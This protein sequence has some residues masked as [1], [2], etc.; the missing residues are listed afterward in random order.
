[1]TSLNCLVGLA[2]WVGLNIPIPHRTERYPTC[3]S[4]GAAHHN[5]PLT[6]LPRKGDY[7]QY[8]TEDIL[9]KRETQRQW[10]MQGLV[11]WINV[12]SLPIPECSLSAT[13][14]PYQSSFPIRGKSEILPFR[15]Y[16][17][18]SQFAQ[19]KLVKLLY[20]SGFL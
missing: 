13:H 10:E 17:G 18:E 2:D 6:G 19:S 11:Q 3:T 1:M 9:E 7:M 20:R 12:A 14:V 5:T 8:M 16:C 15:N 4:T